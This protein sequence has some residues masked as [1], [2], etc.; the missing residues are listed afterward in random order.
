MI[1]CKN[2]PRVSEGVLKCTRCLSGVCPNCRVTIEGQP[3]CGA[4]KSDVVGDI[5]SGV[6]TSSHPQ[7]ASLWARVGAYI[8]DGILMLILY[9]PIIFAIGFS[10]AFV[11]PDAAANPLFNALSVV[12]ILIYL[13][14]EATML[15]KWG[16]T[17]GKMAVRIKVV[18]PN[19]APLSTG[20]AW[21]RAA[22]RQVFYSCLFLIDLL[23]A[24]FTDE[25]T[26]VHDLAARTRVVQ[27]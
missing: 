11:D 18:S 6:V 17:L 15:A 5:R 10:A 19:G 27:A 13:V 16:Q 7:L 22:M 24:F 4:C 8:I 14:Y 21:G 20:Q 2:H 12:F 9:L 1:V 3:Y 25:K 23:P 26:A